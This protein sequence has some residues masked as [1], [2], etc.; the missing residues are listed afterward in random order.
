MIDGRTLVGSTILASVFAVACAA[1]PERAP[2]HDEASAAERS[3]ETVWL[4]VDPAIGLPE[5]EVDDGVMLI[6]A[7]HSPEVRI[8]GVSVVF[9]N[10]SLE[11]G[12][13][14]ARE[15][16]R[17][18]GPE[19]LEVYA[20]AAGA[21]QLGEETEAVRAMARALERESLTLLAVGPVTN[22]ATLVEL[23]PELH[24]RI[25][26]I[27]MVAA[28]RPGQQF[29]SG[30]TPVPFRDFNFELDAAAM[31][32]LL[33]SEIE[34]IFAPWE[35]SSHVWLRA[36][37]LDWLASQSEAGAWLSEACRSWLEVVWQGRLGLDGFNP[38]DT[39]ALAW[40]THPELIESFEGGAW[41]EVLDDDTDP[42]SGETKPYLLVDQERPDLRQVR[43]TYRPAAEFRSVLL[44][45]LSGSGG[46]P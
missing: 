16:V 29:R 11:N 37:D 40:V 20:G 1:S 13:P 31:Q 35:V 26:S 38:F 6:Q 28:R 25:E 45:R 32:R 44:E 46:S 41:I 3:P 23:H 30:G 10:T 19:G 12:V 36:E 14:I 4:D 5:S 18:F 7:F 9:G 2:D 33:D 22:V 42:G 8:A 34:L 15:V 39:L 17:R 21:E 27:V 43:Y 24:D